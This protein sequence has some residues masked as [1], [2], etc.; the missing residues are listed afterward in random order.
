MMH[1]AD[2]DII[3][4]TGIRVDARALLSKVTEASTAEGLDGNVKLCHHR[5]RSCS[6]ERSKKHIKLSSP[7]E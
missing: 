6:G 1:A 2:H 7:S 3:V 5:K 4:S